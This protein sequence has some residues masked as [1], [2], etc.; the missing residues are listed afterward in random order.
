MSEERIDKERERG[1]AGGTHAVRLFVGDLPMLLRMKQVA[2]SSQVY[3]L[4]ALAQLYVLP[5]DEAVQDEVHRALGTGD[6][7]DSARHGLSSS[8]LLFAARVSEAGALAYVETDYEGRDGTQTAAVWQGGVLILAPHTIDT[9][10]ALSRT[11]AVWPINAALRLIGVRASPPDDEFT[12]F[13]LR[14]WASNAEIRSRA[15]RVA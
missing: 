6:W 3:A 11:P 14:H 10:T 1:A 5:F 15:R 13:G 12:T 2:P 8:D 4:T 7:P 9:A